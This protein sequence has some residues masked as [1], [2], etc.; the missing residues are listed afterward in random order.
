MID[1]SDGLASE[2]LHICESSGLGCNLYEEKFPIDPLTFERAREFNLDPTT[3]VLNGGEDYELLF[4][5]AMSEY[6]KIKGNPH[7][8]VIGHMTEKNAGRNLIIR[9]GSSHPITAQG[10]DAF[11]NK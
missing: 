8:T 10:W 4:T 7:I 2:V 3:C 6:D 11:L 9:D 5:V 1:I